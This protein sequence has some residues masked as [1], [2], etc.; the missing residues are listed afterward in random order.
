MLRLLRVLLRVLRNK[1][2]WRLTK[3]HVAFA[4]GK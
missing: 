2:L 3:R 4:T 1:L